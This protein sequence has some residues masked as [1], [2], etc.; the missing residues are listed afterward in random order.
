MCDG[1][2][3][4]YTSL[5]LHNDLYLREGT[6][7]FLPVFCFCNKHVLH[8]LGNTKN[9]PSQYQVITTSRHIIEKHSNLCFTQMFRY[10]CQNISFS[11]FWFLSCSISF[12]LV[13]ILTT[14]GCCTKPYF[15]ENIFF[16]V[17]LVLFLCSCFTFLP[18]HP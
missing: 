18:F 7:P 14:P 3:F 16:I 9:L 8:V 4:S 15:R 12:H 5:I 11:L 2:Q 6:I 1:S 10:S 17:Y 13:K